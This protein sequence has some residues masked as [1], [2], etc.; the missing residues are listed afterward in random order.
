[1]NVTLPVSLQE[2][3]LHKVATGEFKSVDEAVSEGVRLLQHQAE[4]KAD[5]R[6]KIDV[7]WQQAKS[8][9]LHTPD[10]VREN[11]TTRKEAWHHVHGQ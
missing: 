8:G 10:Q 6:H 7:G 3:I 9:D 5:A 1:M 4:W 2:F 11:L